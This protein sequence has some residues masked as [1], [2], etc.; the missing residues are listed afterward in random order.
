MHD[1]TVTARSQSDMPEL[2]VPVLAKGVLAIIFFISGG[3]PQAHKICC[4][5]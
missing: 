4:E 2:A 3:V 5:K 1:L